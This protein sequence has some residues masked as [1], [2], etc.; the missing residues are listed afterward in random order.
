MKQNIYSIKNVRETNR[1][2]ER[3]KIIL[4]FLS[5]MLKCPS[6]QEQEKNAWPIGRIKVIQLFFLQ[7]YDFCARFLVYVNYTK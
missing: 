4:K 1:E 3:E 5:E 6:Q 2:R 7:D